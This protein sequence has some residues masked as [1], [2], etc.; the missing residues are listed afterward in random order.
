MQLSN[1]TI[2]DIIVKISTY[3]RNLSWTINLYHKDHDIV[4]SLAN[5][6][7]S[8]VPFTQKQADL[9]LRL[10]SKY[11]PQIQL[12]YQIDISDS[13]NNPKY[14][15]KIRTVDSRKQISIS[16]DKI[17]VSFNYNE[18]LITEI[19]K[20]KNSQEHFS[21]FIVWN[22]AEKHWEFPLIE[23]NI[24]FLGNI[25]LKE[26]FIADDKFLE[27]YTKCSSMIEDLT[28]YTPYVSF[29]VKPCVKNFHVAIPNL[30]LLETIFFSKRMA[31]KSYD[32]EFYNACKNQNLEDYIQ[33]L[34][35]DRKTINDIGILEN[36][37][38]YN[39]V[40]FILSQGAE[41]K[42]IK[43][44][45]K[46]IDASGINLKTIST[47]VRLKSNFDNGAKFNS[48]IKDNL[49]NNQLSE[50]SK[51]VIIS[52]KLPKPLFN[53]L[54]FDFIITLSSTITNNYL[55]KFMQDHPGII[56]YNIYNNEI[57]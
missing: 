50:N 34:S 2:E 47:L 52:D 29:N 51:I 8:G 48:F 43:F 9:S 26:N 5:Q 4:S 44:I 49:M 30:D 41:L 12:K 14:K 24:L 23:S 46:L 57:T 32:Q 40:L 33:L 15:Y 11:A 55:R 13:I 17:T 35:D 28:T 37:V 10:L 56:C 54:E 20:Y 25:F 38:K 31:I 6:V 1:L 39:K 27:L 53:Y 19:R 3:C 21:E 36:I 18:K 45:K 22:S 16:E 42:S 7:L